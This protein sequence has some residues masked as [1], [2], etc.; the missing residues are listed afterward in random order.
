MTRTRKAAVV[1]AVVAFSVPATAHAARVS[2]VVI[3]KDKA[4]GTFVLAGHSGAATT[5]RA[6]RAHPRLGDMLLVAGPRL[7]GGMVRARSL[8]IVGHTR[9]ATLHAVVVRQL[10]RQ[11]LV[12]AGG[13]VISIWRHGSSARSL[14]M[15]DHHRPGLTTGSVASFGLSISSTG[16]TQTTTTTLGITSTVRIEGHV[17]SVSPL[18][19]SIK[20]LPIT[21]TVPGGV[22]LPPGLQPGDEIELTVSVGDS[23]TFTLVSVDD[24]NAEDQQ[25]VGDDDQGDDNNDQGDDDGSSGGSG[26]TGSDHGGSGSAGGGDGGGSGGGDD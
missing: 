20:G 16:I 3:A 7:T 1:A 26:P 19:V 18:V 13:S 15:V 12:S 4:R 10:A 2:G 21:I 14:S 22:T 25:N 11:T 5:V 24:Q 6:P 8:R 9:H 23:N 17:V